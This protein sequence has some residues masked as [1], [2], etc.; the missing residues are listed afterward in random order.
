M[1]KILHKDI[2]LKIKFH[3][4]DDDLKKYT[5]T[6]RHIVYKFRLKIKLF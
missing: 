1:R 6:D 5:H 2:C 4:S 3:V